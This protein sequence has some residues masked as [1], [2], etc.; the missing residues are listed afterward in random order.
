MLSRLRV[1]L[2]LA[3]VFAVAPA[4]GQ[5]TSSPAP[6]LT[7]KV[8]AVTVFRGQALVTRLVPLPQALTG[9]AGGVREVVITN[10]PG[11]IRPE[12]LHA[13]AAPG[14]AV[15]SV[16]FRTRPVEQDTRSEVRELDNRLEQLLQRQVANKRRQEV[17]AEQRAYLASLQNFVAPAANTELSRGVLNPEAIERLSRF[18]GEQRVQGAETDLKLL[19]EQREL[20]KVIEQAK[21]ERDTVAKGGNRS[22]NEAVVLLALDEAAP[23]TFRLRYLVDG[24]SWEPS[25]NVRSL[26]GSVTLEYQAAIQQMSGEDWSDVAMTLS[27]ATPSLVSAA[28]RLTALNVTLAPLAPTQLAYVDARRELAER[29]RVVEQARARKAGVK[30]KEPG[31]SDDFDRSLN[32]VANDMQV[33]DLLASGEVNRADARELGQAPREEGLSVTYGVPNQTSLPSR[34]ERQL[35]QIAAVPLKASIAKLAAPVLT[36]YIYDEASAVNTSKLVFLAGPVTAYA[37]GAFV[38][39]GDIPTTAVGQSLTVGLGIDSSLRSTRELV[40]RSDS[41]Q[42]GNRV[43]EMTYRLTLEN[44]ADQAAPVRLQDRLPHVDPGRTDIRVTLTSPGQDLSSDTDYRAT[45]YKQGILRWDLVVP[46]SANGREAV[47]LEYTFRLEFDR[48]MGLA[49]LDG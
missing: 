49:G 32:L 48:Q 27:T 36:G 23:A 28:P 39:S 33:L 35:V 16:R 19:A 41:V 21:R 5:A 8:E 26:Q 24:A 47:V 12:S 13:E 11:R 17:A 43:I 2:P 14:L 18:L 15:R 45:Q 25:Y 46:P 42:G 34:A 29:Q 44:F 38:G 1:A 3:A 7:G 22:V 37:E 20:E 4:F 31:G 10:L 6:E 9:A 40:K 30:D